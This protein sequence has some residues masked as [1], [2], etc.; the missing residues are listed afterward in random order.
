MLPEAP[1]LWSWRV[2]KYFL[3]G[4]WRAWARRA[5]ICLQRVWQEVWK[6]EIRVEEGESVDGRG[7]RV[8][9]RA[10]GGAMLK[11]LSWV[12]EE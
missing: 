5:R 6:L 2:V 1:A 11:A 8:G 10:L 3:S 12:R 9:W 7:W 4:I